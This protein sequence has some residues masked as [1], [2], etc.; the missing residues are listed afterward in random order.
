M[1]LFFFCLHSLLFDVIFF[2][3]KIYQ[4]F[5]VISGSIPPASASQ[6]LGLQKQASMPDHT[7]C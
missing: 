1:N 4:H 7:I 6:I 5:Q 3:D 2:S